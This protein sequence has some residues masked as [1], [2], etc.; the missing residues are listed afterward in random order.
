MK[1]ISR[2]LLFFLLILCACSQRN[3]STN[4][5]NKVDSNARIEVSEAVAKA[6]SKK[7]NQKQAVP[8]FNVAPKFINKYVQAIG[9]P[10][11]GPAHWVEHS[12]LLTEN[13][14][15]QYR[16]ISKS[17][18]SLDSD[19]IL[20]ANF[21]PG[22]RFTILKADSIDGYVTLACDGQWKD[23]QLVLKL[24]HEEDNWLVDGSGVVNIPE[25]KRAK[26]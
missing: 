24:A 20:D 19:P 4:T 22:N 14:K 16:K 21:L 7:S 6:D 18:D 12:P 2:C 8:D 25:G 26:R 17:D 23:Y 15:N 13:F 5:V 9:G 11:G 3:N 1:K 10:N